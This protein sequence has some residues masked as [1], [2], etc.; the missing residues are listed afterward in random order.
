M[1]AGLCGE[2]LGCFGETGYVAANRVTAKHADHPGSGTSTMA[3]PAR[4]ALS[5]GVAGLVVQAWGDS[6]D[7]RRGRDRDRD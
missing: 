5:G 1:S 7:P 2:L 3:M 4:E 6:F